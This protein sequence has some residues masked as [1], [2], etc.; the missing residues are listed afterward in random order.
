MA[1]GEKFVISAVARIMEPGCKADY[2]LILEGPQDWG[3]S[4][5]PRILA[6]DD[7]F[8]DQLADIG[9]KDA[10]MQVRGCW[11]V[12]LGELD[13][14]NRPE[15]SKV[16]AFLTRQADRFRLPYGHRVV[17]F[18]RQCVFMG[19]TNKYEWLKDESGGRRFWPVRCTKKIDVARLAADR[20]QLWAEALRQY[21]AAAH[22]WLEDAGL[23]EEAKEEQ[24]GRYTPDPWEDRI[25]QFVESAV[26]ISVWEILFKL[27][28]ETA[29]QDQAAANRVAKCLQRVGWKRARLEADEDGKR[30]WGYRRVSK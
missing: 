30:P 19:T 17:K 12:E 29:K 28:V 22:W 23:I 25:R 15:M 2:L 11:I 10:D 8:T 5:V 13:A 9:N 21:H 20:D 14:F 16:K 6:G 27:G 7:W 4:T 1:V 26:S 3:K 18:P 24:S